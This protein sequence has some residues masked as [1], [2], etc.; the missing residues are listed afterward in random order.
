M[1]AGPS[2]PTQP[3]RMPYG[4]GLA[5]NYGIEGAPRVVVT[6]VQQ[7]AELAVTELLFDEPP[8]R[9]SDPI[10]RQDAYLVCCQ[11]RDREPFEYWEE[12]RSLGTCSLRAGDT[13]IR[14]L[15][16]DPRAMTDGPRHSVV[17]FVPRA[18]LN[19]LAD[20]ANVPYVDELRFDPSVGIAD[21]TIW[22]ISALMLPALKTPEQVSRLF[23]DHISLA[24]AAHVAQAYGGM[25]T[26]SRLV[27]GGLA[28]WQERR[29]KEILVA[30]LTG[31]VPLAEIAAACSLS[32]DHFAR[33]FR[34]STGL[35]P[36]AWLLQ[37]RVERAMALL[38]QPDPSLSEIAL[39]C[40]FVDQSHFT[41]VF[42]ARV[43][44]TPRAWRDRVRG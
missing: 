17:W 33:A 2:S 22:H 44:I 11:F 9:I 42:G 1:N 12:G 25:Q 38:R 13:T 29:A 5:A 6:R 18:A 32:S 35:A 23:S 21:E 34:R 41:R 20:E 30:D 8:V 31:A 39:A 24:L 28:P 15:Q 3:R 37:A 19:A 27:K 36:H 43:G 16:R 10:P 40:G 4:E 26:G 14:D 7:H